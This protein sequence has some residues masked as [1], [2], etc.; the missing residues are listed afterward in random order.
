[1]PDHHATEEKLRASGLDWTFLRHSV[2]ADFEA[3][4][5]AAAARTGKLVTNGG[6]GKLAYVARDDCAAAA[7]AVLAA[8]GHAGKAY[9]ITGPESLDADARAALFAELAGRPV[10]VVHVDDDAFAAGTAEATGMPLE[11]A[12]MYATF[13]T[14]TGWAPSTSSA[15][16]T[17]SRSP[18]APRARC[19]TSSTA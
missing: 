17:S 14:A 5:L 12:Q 8:G 3:G 15:A 9:D 7:A 18:A 19:A 16:T 13:G 11:A 2:Y 4:E 6:D 10:E 1:M